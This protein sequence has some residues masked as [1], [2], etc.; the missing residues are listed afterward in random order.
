MELR[1]IVSIIWERKY[2]LLF[3]IASCLFL[4]LVWL[5]SQPEEYTVFFS[6]DITRK[7]IQETPDYRY[8]QFYRLQAD[9]KF[10][11]TIVQWMGDADF[12]KQV[13]ENYQGN[14]FSMRNLSAV[15]L[16]SSY[17]KI[18]FKTKNQDDSKLLAEAIKKSLGDRIALVGGDDST[19]FSVET[20]D[21]IDYRENYNWKIIILGAFLLGVVLGIFSALFHYYWTDDEKNRD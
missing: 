3:I 18:F 21:P 19:W 13:L 15:R 10:A 6:V 2:I 14:S 20:T 12:N 9:E 5:F 16:S 17:L 1:Q 11:D 4:A 8:D 7:N